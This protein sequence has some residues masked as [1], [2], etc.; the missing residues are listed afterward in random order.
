MMLLKKTVYDKIVA[1]VNNINTSGFLLKT[2]YNA[3]QLDLEKK[4][5]D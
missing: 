3:N 5:S 2:K 1:K 4:M